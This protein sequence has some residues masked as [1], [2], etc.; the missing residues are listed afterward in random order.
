MM[1]SMFSGI[2]GLKNFQSSM[3]I[4]A[5]NI[6]N[7]STPGF[8]AFRAEFE[9]AL[10][11]TLRAAAAPQ[12]SRG[13]INPQQIGL[14]SSIASIDK[15][16]A[17]GSLENTGKMTDLAIQGD[18][19]FILSD[20]TNRFYTR[21][22]NFSL[23]TNG[24]LVSAANGLTVQ[25]WLAKVGTNGKRYVDRNQPISTIQL[26]AGMSM[27]AKA[28]TA[29]E[30]ADNLKSTADVHPVTI[31]ITDPDGDKG[32]IR[33]TFQRVMDK[34]HLD[35]NFYIW[36]AEKINGDVTLDPRTTGG[37]MELDDSGNVTT[38]SIWNEYTPSSVDASSG[39]NIT[40][41][42][43]HIKLLD[44]SGN[45]VL[46][47]TTKT[48][49]M[50]FHNPGAA[51]A[52]FELSGTTIAGDTFDQTF[53]ISSADANDDST[54]TISEFNAY[55][56]ASPLSNAYYT[57]SNFQLTGTGTDAIADG[58]SL[59]GDIAHHTFSKIGVDDRYAIESVTPSNSGTPPSTVNITDMA[60]D[61]ILLDSSGNPVNADTTQNIALTFTHTAVNTFGLALTFTKQDGTQASDT[62]DISAAD[63][64]GDDTLTIDE[65][66]TY[67]QSNPL[68]GSTYTLKGFTLLGSGDINPTAAAGTDTDVLTVSLSPTDLINVPSQGE[69]R[70]TETDNVDNYVTADYES[71]V[72]VAPM[73]VYDSLGH[74][75]NIYV[76]FTKLQQNAWLWEAESTTG[77]PIY[78]LDAEGNKM[79]NPDTG[80]NDLPARGV[81]AFDANG[82]LAASNWRIDDDGNIITSGGPS[83]I[84][85]EPAETGGALSST[86]SPPS[87]AGANTVK[88][89]MD[90]GRVS[91]YDAPS[92]AD[93]R[94]QNGNAEGTLQSF[95]I[96]SNGEIVG[97]FSN[98]L[99]DTLGQVA[100]ATFNNPSGL[101]SAGNSMYRQ[102]AN[103]GIPVI[104]QANTG[105][106]GSISAGALEMSNVDLAEEFTKMII[107]QR[108]FQANARVITTTDEILRDLVNIKR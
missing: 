50:T 19:F 95:A 70:F 100:L 14:G 42:S 76:R 52:T 7:V 84:W 63:T 77:E 108:G 58:D 20:G 75:Y 12:G 101:T 40:G 15:I 82:K 4:L 1:R 68:V 93:L 24:T 62:F 94:D 51:N 37:T 26:P 80:K 16:M 78:A 65:F 103:S 104:G 18:G 64:N 3:D 69:I 61:L 49:T 2:T 97:A 99:T 54:L 105:G 79:P 56:A 11:Q 85:F 28:T 41:L 67:I 44:S 88:I 5:N 23:D 43:G 55:I 89:Q 48:V 25:G 32:T 45:P 66:N 74:M 33:F 73:E 87:A 22:G 6:S 59:S 107:A 102:S 35:K 98:G 83:G 72:H 81:I 21:N 60:G 9:S 30:F 31:E 10:L 90:F 13:G 71:P 57:L 8:K 53:D 36:K 92:T 27:E 96:N 106:R 29:A 46:L 34:T 91:Q 38:F 39:G 47:D 17:Q 86:S